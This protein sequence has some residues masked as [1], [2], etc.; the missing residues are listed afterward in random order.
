[1]LVQKFS[2]RSTK[3]KNACKDVIMNVPSEHHSANSSKKIEKFL[4]GKKIYRGSKQ[5]S[6]GG[7]V[8]TA[9]KKA[10]CIAQSNSELS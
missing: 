2:P 1:M 5:R 6:S 7:G 8:F 3:N 4:C 9:E 10:Y